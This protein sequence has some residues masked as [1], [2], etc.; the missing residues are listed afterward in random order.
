LV[1]EGD[2]VVSEHAGGYSDWEARVTASTAPVQSPRERPAPAAPASAPAGGKLNKRSY[3][4]QRE[5]DNL[6][7]AIEALEQQQRA[8][9]EAISRA[10]FYQG[11]RA[12]VDATLAQLARVQAEL[13]QLFERW[14]ALEQG[15]G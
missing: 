5:L 15:E 2:G 11:A 9:E 3:K 7:R 4:L 14:A 10:D 13:E 8:L 1:L 6:P 12:K